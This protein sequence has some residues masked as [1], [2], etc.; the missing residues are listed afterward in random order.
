MALWVEDATENITAAAKEEFLNYGFID[1]SLRRI[2]DKANTSP[3]S[4]YTRFSDKEELFAYFVKE[5]ADY[6]L[7][8]VEEYLKNFAAA[9]KEEQI[10]SRKEN[11][12]NLAQTLL[13]YIYDNFDAFYLIVCCSK[14]TVYDN[15]IEQ[16]AALETQYTQK[17]LIAIDSEI[18]KL[19]KVTLEFI[20]MMSRSFFDGFFE[21]V[22]HRFD[23]E[24]AREHIEK[25]ILF[26]N[27]GWEKFLI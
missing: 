8:G 22:R 23:R 10:E 5:Q 17:Y 14:G 20:H 26:H 21:I 27:G 24:K 19:P 6:F 15:F 11:S 2:A 25:L 9:P 16:I 18:R 12:S 1:A 13:D 3:R 4:I 7:S